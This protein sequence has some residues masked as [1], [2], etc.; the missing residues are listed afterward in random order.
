ML[1]YNIMERLFIL[2]NP[3]PRDKSLH[4]NLHM[5]RRAFRKTYPLLEYR[6]AYVG[7]PPK[8]CGG[9]DGFNGMG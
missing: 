4:V 7:M 5:L 8:V 2:K 1:N 9:K 6:V 3:F